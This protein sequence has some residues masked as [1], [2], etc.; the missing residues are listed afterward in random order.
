MQVTAAVL[1]AEGPREEEVRLAAD[2][3]LFCGEEELL[4]RA[5]VE[6]ALGPVCVFASRDLSRPAVEG[7]FATRELL[8]FPPV[9]PLR[10]TE[11]GL[12]ALRREELAAAM[13]ESKP[14]LRPAAPEPTVSVSAPDESEEAPDCD[15]ASEAPPSADEDESCWSSDE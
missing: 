2:W 5:C 12:Q 3:R 1:T 4:L 9:V 7:L 14:K 11:R 13:R 8:L 6:C 15:E 10:K